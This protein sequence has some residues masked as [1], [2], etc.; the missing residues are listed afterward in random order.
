MQFADLANTLLP[1]VTD[2]QPSIQ[3]P[4]LT[5]GSSLSTFADPVPM[6]ESLV[7][8]GNVDTW[9]TGL[10]THDNL[11]WSAL[12]L[13]I[14]G[15]SEY[16]DGGND[17]PWI[18]DYSWLMQEP[19]IDTSAGFTLLDQQIAPTKPMAGIDAA[20]LSSML[21]D[22]QPP[23]SSA[24]QQY[25]GTKTRF[26]NGTPLHPAAR[27]RAISPV[28]GTAEEDPWPMNWRHPAREFPTIGESS[29]LIAN[30]VTDS[31]DPSL[32]KWKNYCIDAE[33]YEKV[34]KC[35]GECSPI[36]CKSPLTLQPSTG[37]GHARLRRQE[38][39]DAYQ[40]RYSQYLHISRVKFVC[41]HHL[42]QSD[43]NLV[44]FEHFYRQFPVLH[45]P[46]FQ[47][48][49]A[50]PLLLA[51]LICIGSCYCELPGARDL[52]LDLIEVIRKT[53]NALFENDARNV[54]PTAKNAEMSITKVALSTV[55]PHDWLHSCLSPHRHC[56]TVHWQ[57]THI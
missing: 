14:G 40:P 4:S 8:S 57:Q 53:L 15:P 44:Y 6:L 41:L 23:R 1:A 22:L 30:I 37:R 34:K 11:I 16:I 35:F 48:N 31:I 12:G 49:K 54:G 7:G 26:G 10:E 29:F 13:D 38:A 33:T 18:S 24:S 20:L 45:L 51:G 5:G 39:A 42:S 46:T 3:A 55:A 47:P 52:A 43:F 32:Q 9:N 19:T 28:D 50:P 2:E 27:S 56:W 25:D 21:Q 17:I 36:L